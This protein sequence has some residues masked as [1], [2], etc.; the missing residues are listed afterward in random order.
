[1]L[2]LKPL[3]LVIND[4]ALATKARINIKPKWDG[5]GHTGELKSHLHKLENALNKLG[6]HSRDSKVTRHLTSLKIHIGNGEMKSH[7][8]D[9]IIICT[10]ASKTKSRAGVGIIIKE[11]QVKHRFRGR[12]LQDKLSTKQLERLALAKA[13][14]KITLLEP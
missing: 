8:D 3:C 2:G 10:D 5:L 7:N 13:A 14:D 9:E 12:I 6:V 4:I 11:G 1:M